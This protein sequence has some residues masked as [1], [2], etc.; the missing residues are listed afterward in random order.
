MTSTL[1]VFVL[2]SQMWCFSFCIC[3]CEV[4]RF[5]CSNPG[6]HRTKISLVL[7]QFTVSSVSFLMLS[8]TFLLTLWSAN[9]IGLFAMLIAEQPYLLHLIALKSLYELCPEYILSW[10]LPSNHNRYLMLHFSKQ[11]ANK[12]IIFPF[13]H[14]RASQQDDLIVVSRTN[15][16]Q[17]TDAFRHAFHWRLLRKTWMVSDNLFF[18]FYSA[19]SILKVMICFCILYVQIPMNW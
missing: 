4:G 7:L 6:G 14:S 10:S 2:D 8:N 5:P 13:S 1:L 12:P 9:Q 18:N 3:N 16:S 19:G 11:Q 17:L 15:F